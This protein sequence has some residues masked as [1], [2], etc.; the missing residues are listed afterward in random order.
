[1]NAKMKKAN[2]GRKNKAGKNPQATSGI[3]P[4]GFFLFPFATLILPAIIPGLS[5]SGR[6]I[7]GKKGG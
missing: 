1:M 5:G 7:A 6:L 2:G 3:L 4:D